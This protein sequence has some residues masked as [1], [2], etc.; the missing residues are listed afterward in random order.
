MGKKGKVQTVS[1]RQ[2]RNGSMTFRSTG[3]FDLRK[4]FPA[5]FKVAEPNTAESGEHQE[6]LNAVAAHNSGEKQ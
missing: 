1:I 5:D 4:L 6:V 2:H 3:G